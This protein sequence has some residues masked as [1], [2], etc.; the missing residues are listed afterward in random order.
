ME[1]FY[2]KTYILGFQNGNQVG[3]KRLNMVEYDNEWNVIVMKSK[4][5][6]DIFLNIYIDTKYLQCGKFKPNRIEE[7]CLC[8]IKCCLLEYNKNSLYLTER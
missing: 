1:Q 2:S 3:S 8:V 7:R 5:K 4:Y 6:V